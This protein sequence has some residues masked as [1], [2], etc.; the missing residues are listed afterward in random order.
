MVMIVAS[1]RPERDPQLTQTLNDLAWIPFI[2]VFPPVMIQAL[3][4]AVAILNKPDQD[5]FPRWLAYFN[6]WCAVLFLPAVLIPF[7]KRGPFA[8][9]G[10]LEFWLA[11]VVF[12]GWFAVMTVGLLGAI[13]RQGEAVGLST[14]GVGD[15]A[16]EGQRAAEKLAFAGSELAI[17][18]LGEPILTRSPR[19]LEHFQPLR[20]ELDESSATIAGVGAPG[21]ETCRL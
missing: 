6:V 7:F 3:S 8:W 15:A 20:R 17:Q 18:G 5:V 16:Y 11:A 9:H 12:F 10:L 4:I 14:S 2:M 19:R 13:K 1:F 21:H